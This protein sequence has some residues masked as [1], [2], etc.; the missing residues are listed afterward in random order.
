[1][2]NPRKANRAPRTARTRALL[3]LLL[4][5]AAAAPAHAIERARAD[6][7][8]RFG[9]SAGTVSLIQGPYGVLL[10]AEFWNLS[11]GTHAFHVH[12]VGRCTPPFESAGGHYNPR[13]LRHGFLDADGTHAGDMPNLHVPASGAL[14]VDV[15]LSDVNLDAWLLDDD[16]SSLVVHEGPDDYRSE[17]AGAAGPRIACGVIVPE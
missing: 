14:E 10:R 8:N 6:M 4:A 2:G 1:M 5:A 11:T 9:H 15:F 13:G 3:V 7:Q 17:P 16:G 12:A